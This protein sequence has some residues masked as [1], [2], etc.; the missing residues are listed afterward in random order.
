MYRILCIY[1]LMISSLIS[2]SQTYWRIENEHHDEILLTIDLN[3]TKQT[4]E[5]YTRRDAL[6]DI[7]GT[8]TYTL[9]KAA[10][11][12]KYPEIVF[13]EGKTQNKADSLFLTGTFNYFDKQFPFSASINGNHFFGKYFDKKNKPHPLN[14]VKVPDNKPLKDYSSIINSAFSVTEIYLFKAEWLKS[15]EWLSFRE[16][17][18][19]LKPKISDDYELAAS[20]FWLGKKLPFSPYEISKSD[21]RDRSRVRKNRVSVREL[22]PDV[23]LL[24][25]N[26]M[27]E[28]KHQMDSIAAIIDK[29]GYSKLIID[30]RGNYRQ[31]PLAANALVNYISDKAFVAGVYLTRKWFDANRMPPVNQDYKKLF[32]GFPDGKYDNGE[33][34]KLSGSYLFVNPESKT[35]RGKTYILTDSKTSKVFEA[36]IYALKKEKIAT[37]VGQKTSGATMLSEKF[38][39]NKDYE[40]VLPVSDFYTCDGKSLDRM[41]VE[42]DIAVSGDDALNYILK[43]L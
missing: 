27:P 16:K 3:R 13:I 30:L 28:T 10:G 40:L 21:L 9:A 1:F 4:F 24:E 23:A 8:F 14:G 34:S 18:N 32:A 43:S 7:A 25:A 31:N 2:V 12:L 41:G 42:P 5:A 15:D 38:L 6:K 33:L 19:D 11:K 20:F 35:F 26:T 29:K 39:I 36:L 37:I 17:L 22:K